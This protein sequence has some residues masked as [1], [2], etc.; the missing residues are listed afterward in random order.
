MLNNPIFSF[1]TWIKK[2]ILLERIEYDQN[3]KHRVSYEENN[4]TIKTIWLTNTTEYQLL[5]Q[6]TVSA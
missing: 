5:N 6:S 2:N 1:L 3:N 4:I